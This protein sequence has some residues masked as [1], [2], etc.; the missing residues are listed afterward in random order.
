MNRLIFLTRLCACLLLIVGISRSE[1]T[2]VRRPTGEV[3]S[4]ASA[5]NT[6]CGV[7]FRGR[8]LS[9]INAGE[10][11]TDPRGSHQYDF[12]RSTFYSLA[13]FPE[14]SLIGAS[15]GQILIQTPGQLN[16]WIRAIVGTDDI[17]SFAESRGNAGVRFIAGGFGGG[18]RVSDD[19]GKTWAASNGGLA[20]LNVTSL[21]SGLPLPDSSGQMVFAGTYGNGV[22]ASTDNGQSWF[23]R[24][25]TISS[26]QTT[27][28]TAAHSGIYV[29]GSG[30][31]VFRSSD[32]GA[33]WQELGT[34][35][36]YTELL[37]VGTVEDGIEEW[38]YCGTV[39]AGVWRCPASG[40][41]WAPMNSGLGNLRIND[42]ELNG[43]GL[44]AGTYEGVYRSYDRGV[45]WAFIGEDWIRQPSVIHALPAPGPV[46]KDVLLAGASLYQ[47]AWNYFSTA[48]S[49]ADGGEN[50]DTTAAL[51]TAKVVS[52]A[53]H[54]GLL[55]LLSYG[56]ID[57][58]P[59]GGLH[60]SSD[61]GTTWEHRPLDIMLPTLFSSMSVVSR[62]DGLGLD[63]YVGTNGGPAPG[64]FFSS[65]TGHSW[66]R[67]RGRGANSIDVIDSFLVIRTGDSTLRTSDRG[68]TWADITPNVGS[69]VILSLVNDG[70]RLFG[71]TSHDPATPGSGG[72][73]M[74]SDAGSTWLPAGLEGSTVT[75][76]VPVDNHILAVADGKIFATR[77]E[78]FEWVEVTDNLFGTTVGM[79]TATPQYCYAMGINGRSIWR[80]PMTEI[81]QLF[82]VVP[83]APA[84]VAPMNGATDQPV[85]LSLQWTTPAL[86][87]SFRFQCSQDSTF[88]GTFVSD[89]SLVDS[90][91]VVGTLENS[92]T[93]Y[94]RVRAA[95]QTGIGPW[96]AIRW[97]T[98]IKTIVALPEMIAL[99]T[100]HHR[101]SIGKDSVRVVWR[102]GMP[103]IQRYWIEY[104]SDSLFTSR[105]VD[106]TVTDTT[107]VIRNLLTGHEY[108]WRVKAYNDAG[109][110]LF[111][112]PRSFSV[113]ITGLDRG[114]LI[115]H[116]FVLFQNHP[117][118]FN[119]TTSIRFGLPKAAFVRL[120]VY[121]ILGEKLRSILDEERSAGYHEVQFDASGFASGVYFYRLEAGV[122]VE[123]KHLLLLR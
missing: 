61:M 80:R 101:A 82:T 112:D 75:S 59:E 66:R 13:F 97:F 118:P 51:F 39:D 55:M 45:S 114:D 53:H 123:T 103:E 85:S 48:L 120:D 33:S 105:S 52:I 23:S 119:P 91:L 69:N 86:T 76:L 36:P 7:G 67:I 47:N 100:P 84:L 28:M 122:F 24:G 34:G 18:I 19:S 109:W 60:V 35:L 74:T 111:S 32:W 98:T 88:S 96:S 5:G 83:A 116:E 93:Y 113:T 31:K 29:A 117:N 72:V 54:D 62:K 6:L 49:T 92:R 3:L 8:L 27:A 102:A 22:F 65:D 57:M 68:T 1:W 115:P 81:L 46:G 106:S 40:G 4:L 64:V 21:V 11:W 73:W 108:W 70:E 56:T 38:V 104:A 87:S 90:A 42:I 71:C 26:F 43:E 25:Q 44:Y 30:G 89:T 77:R 110:G 10:S 2:R 99:S 37:C 95:N 15:N 63:S 16:D 17:H 79:I 94:W 20:N 78:G 14:V 41:T 58:G 12:Y 107:R 50:W 9:T 121:S